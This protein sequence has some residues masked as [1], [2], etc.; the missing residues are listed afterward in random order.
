MKLTPFVAGGALALLQL[1]PL[2]CLA[3]QTVTPTPAPVTPLPP[4]QLQTQAYTSCVMNCDTASGLCQSGCSVG[5]TP[6]STA[7]ASGALSQC[8]LNC[9]T[10]QLYCKNSCTPPPH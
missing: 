9:S 2:P 7:S 1:I 10:Q 5:N 3:Q 4:V 6:A 8:Y